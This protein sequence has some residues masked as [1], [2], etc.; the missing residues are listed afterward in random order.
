[1]NRGDQ[2]KCQVT[3]MASSLPSGTKRAKSPRETEQ[4]L[5]RFVTEKRSEIRRG[6]LLFRFGDFYGACYEDAE[7]VARILG[8]PI[9]TRRSTAGTLS[10][11]KIPVEQAA[12]I[13]RKLQDAGYR[14]GVVEDVEDGKGA[15]RS[16]V[17]CL[18]PNASSTAPVTAPGRRR[19]LCEAEP[20]PFKSPA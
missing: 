7:T 8:I 12:T 13:F 10:L 6:I 4:S 3:Q 15:R 16:Y 11:A 18:S 20:G 14:L 1:M 5:R 2:A 9:E 17:S 19:Q